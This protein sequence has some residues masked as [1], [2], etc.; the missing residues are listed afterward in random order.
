MHLQP[1]SNQIKT[2]SAQFCFV[3][4]LQHCFFIN[5]FSKFCS[6]SYALPASICSMWILKSGFKF[7][8]CVSHK[9]N[10]K[11]CKAV[12][13]KIWNLKRFPVQDTALHGMV[14]ALVSHLNT[15]YSTL[16]RVFKNTRERDLEVIKPWPSCL[17]AYRREGF[18]WAGHCSTVRGI[19]IP[20]A[21]QTNF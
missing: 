20:F 17:P 11:C 3:L 19:Q 2:G 9:I 1:E 10:F 12:A 18:C 4:V 16:K 7:I 21:A 15:G 5:V 6:V 14:C 13:G 8:K